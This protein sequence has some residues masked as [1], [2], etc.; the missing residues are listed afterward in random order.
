MTLASIMDFAQAILGRLL[1][2]SLVGVL[3]AYFDDSGTHAGAP[4]VA[5]GGLLGTAEQW[6]EFEN[7]WS[8]LLANPLP[9]KPPLSMFHLSACRARDDE[10]R[11]Y[12]LAERDRITYLFRQVILDLGLVTIAQAVNQTIWSELIVGQFAE[13]LGNPLEFCFVKCVDLVMST[14]RLR[15]PGQKV[16]II[17]D[18]ATRN[19]LGELASFYLSQDDKYPEIAGIGFG[20]VSETLPL[21]GADMIATETYQYAQEWIRN[22]ENPI[23]NPH[24]RDYIYRELSSGFILDRSGIEEILERMRSGSALKWRTS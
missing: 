9:S 13:Q 8:Q 17:F 24:F 21:Q 14:I 10:F 18:R 23:P 5:I 22:R 16:A 2:G 12:N 19:T 11:D 3:A 1:N 15:K 6:R 20:K 7:R 4:V